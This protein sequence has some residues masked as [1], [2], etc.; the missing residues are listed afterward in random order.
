MWMPDTLTATNR[1]NPSPVPATEE[2]RSALE[3]HLRSTFKVSTF[4]VCTHQPL[5]MMIGPPLRLNVD[6][7]ATPVTVH[8][9]ASVPVHWEKST[10]TAMS[11]S[12]YWK[13][14]QS[15]HLTSPNGDCRQSQRRTT[16]SRRFPTPQPP[17]NAGDTP[18]EVSVPPGTQCPQGGEEERVRRVER[19]PLSSITP[20]GH[21][22]H[23]FYHTL[24]TVSLL[25]RPPGVQS[26]R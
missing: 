16:M 9:A 3:Q 24:G 4:N 13:R 2:N 22:L 18:H 8:K 11:V 20:G 15:A 14:S 26:I 19:I 7:R 10:S 1:P 23:Y 25:D 5:P 12:G 17:C 6:P 21:A